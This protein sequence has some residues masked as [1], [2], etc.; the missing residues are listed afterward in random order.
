MYFSESYCSVYLL[1]PH[2]TIEDAFVLSDNLLQDSEFMDVGKEYLNASSES[3][4]YLSYKN[5]I[6]LAFEQASWFFVP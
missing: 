5:S 1:I 2:R 3:P 4:L 6:M